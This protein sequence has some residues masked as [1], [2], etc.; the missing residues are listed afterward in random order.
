MRSF[1][2]VRDAKSPVGRARWDVGGA[3]YL[4][5]RQV[6]VVRRDERRPELVAADDA[7]PVG[8]KV[9][10]GA[11]ATFRRRRPTAVDVSLEDVVAEF[12]EARRRER[13]PVA[14]QAQR[15]QS[16]AVTAGTRSHARS[17]ARSR[18]QAQSRQSVT[19]TVTADTAQRTQGHAQGRGDRR[20]ASRA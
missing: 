6:E 13:R 5:V 9:A 7:H 4:D 20:S 3:P 10:R 11:A 2:F 8:V 17:R 18:R 14:R 12:E 15:Q 16:V 19:V 1:R